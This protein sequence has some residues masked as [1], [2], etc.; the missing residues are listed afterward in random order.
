MEKKED[1]QETKEYYIPTY[2]YIACFAIG[3]AICYMAFMLV[4]SIGRVLL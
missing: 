4:V 3:A 1:T 2:V